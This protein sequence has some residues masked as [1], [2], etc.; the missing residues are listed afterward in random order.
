MYNYIIKNIWT[1]RLHS[2]LPFAKKIYENVRVTKKLR[3]KLHPKATNS[4]KA[5]I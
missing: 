3:T 4:R 2:H 1:R 5:T